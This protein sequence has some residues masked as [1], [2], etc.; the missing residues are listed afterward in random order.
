[1]NTP[2]LVRLHQDCAQAPWSAR[3]ADASSTSAV[4]TRCTRATPLRPRTRL[5]VCAASQ[6]PDGPDRSHGTAAHP[7]PSFSRACEE[8][9]GIWHGDRV[10]LLRGLRRVRLASASL[11]PRA[12]TSAPCRTISTPCLFSRGFPRCSVCLRIIF[13]PPLTCCCTLLAGVLHWHRPRCCARPCLS[14][15]GGAPEYRPMPQEA[16]A[17]LTSPASSAMAYA[18]LAMTSGCASARPWRAACTASAGV[19]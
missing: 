3:P 4:H 13:H 17:F 14:H 1:M 11:H 19:V 8:A 12:C 2:R 6:G 10:T 18:D 16:A 5:Q 15:E 9:R 7:R